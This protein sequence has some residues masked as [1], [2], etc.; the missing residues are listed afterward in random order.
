MKKFTLIAAILAG[1]FALG[2]QNITLDLTKATTDLKFNETTGQWTGTFND[3]LESIDSQC[4]SFVHSSMGEYETWWGFTASNSA[5]NAAKENYIT[6]QYSNM[7]KGGIA[8]NEDGSVKT[9]DHG[10]PVVDPKVPYLVAYYSP[11]MANRPVDMVFTDG[12]H[13]A[14]GVYVNLNSYAYYS[15]MDGDNVARAFT[16]GDKFTLTIHGVAA[17]ESE[18][19]VEVSLASYNNGDITV[20]RGWKYVDL[21]SLGAVNELYF[22]LNSTDTGKYGMNTP[23]YFCLD[24]LTVKAAASSGVDDVTTQN[25][26]VYD[27]GSKT[28]SLNGSDF[29]IVYNALGNQ[30]MTAEG[31]SFSVSDLPAGVYIIRSG[32]SCLKIAK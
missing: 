15:V 27:R 10:A 32:N 4:F 23:G 16:N 28:V 7:A 22:T 19:A 6:W 8:L 21:S 1:T 17:D 3:D 13:E 30:V 18:K 12:A 11:F 31:T 20:T 25:H 9:D 26:I 14:I 5:D 24:K 2:A 29:A